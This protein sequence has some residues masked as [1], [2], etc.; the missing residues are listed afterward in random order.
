MS[1]KAKAHMEL[2]YHQ[3]SLAKIGEFVACYKNPSAAINVVI[4]N[5]TSKIMEKKIN[6]SDRI[7]AEHREHY[8][9]LE[10]AGESINQ[11]N[12]IELARFRAETDQILAEHLASA[13]RNV[14]YTS[15]T[16]SK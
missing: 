16:N 7:L 11:E 13:P 2:E 14:K 6:K 12:F 9:N 15:K 5:E 10:Q 4:D 1:V 8:F 3:A